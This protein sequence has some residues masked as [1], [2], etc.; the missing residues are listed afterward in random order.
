MTSACLWMNSRV[1]TPNPRC[2][3]RKVR[4]PALNLPAAQLA[5]FSP[6]VLLFDGHEPGASRS[7]QAAFPQA[8]SILDAGSLRPGIEP[9]AASVDYL[10]ASERFA[11]Q[12]T[13]LVDLAGGARRK[14]CLERLRALAKPGATIV[15]TLGER[16][17]IYDAGGTCRHLPACRVRTVDT[18]GAG[19]VFHGA[20]AYGVLQGLPVDRIVKLASLASA[21]SVQ[22]RG[23]RRS[24]PS[25]DAV[26]SEFQR[27]EGHDVPEY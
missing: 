23:S 8:T 18:T 19:D 9:L 17:L 16:G 25:L 21:L 11:L 6:R 26:R 15:V 4:R 10:A 7:V 20:F 22:E 3:N 5:G 24:I 2:T 14:E 27:M 1:R 12:V 13:G